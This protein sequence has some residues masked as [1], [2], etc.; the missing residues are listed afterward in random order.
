MSRHLV[1][2]LKLKREKRARDAVMGNVVCQLGWAMVPDMQSNI[3]LDV[4][5]R[6]FWDEINV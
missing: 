2:G 3:I 1:P 5:V 4:S 6:V